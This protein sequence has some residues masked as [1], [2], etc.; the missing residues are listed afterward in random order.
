MYDFNIF[1][2]MKKVF[3]LLQSKAQL[4]YS[5][6]YNVNFMILTIALFV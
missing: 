4:I 6:L 1:Y 2:F 3:T 5:N